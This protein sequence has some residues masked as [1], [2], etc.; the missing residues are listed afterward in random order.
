[1]AIFL[2]P[3]F[4]DV[5]DKSL[6]STWGIAYPEKYDFWFKKSVA[7]FKRSLP[8]VFLLNAYVVIAPSNVKFAIYLHALEIFY[9][10]G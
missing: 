7:G 1:V 10:L 3:W 5:V 2:V 4:Q 6:K 9:T 8:L